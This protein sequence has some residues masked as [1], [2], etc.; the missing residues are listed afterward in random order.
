MISII[1]TLL[2]IASFEVAGAAKDIGGH[3][4]NEIINVL[5]YYTIDKFFQLKD[6]KFLETSIFIIQV[7]ILGK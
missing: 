2:V 4:S 5:D 7:L 6:I 3:S 1:S